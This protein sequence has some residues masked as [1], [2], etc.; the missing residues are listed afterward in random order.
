VD[1]VAI[2][3][4]SKSHLKDPQKHREMGD[5]VVFWDFDP[6]SCPKVAP[7]ICWLPLR[8]IETACWELT[9]HAWSRRKGSDCRIM[10]HLLTPRKQLER[11]RR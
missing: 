5:F 7:S 9:E 6:W 1:A 8:A 4:G 11:D 3:S 2:E 10:A